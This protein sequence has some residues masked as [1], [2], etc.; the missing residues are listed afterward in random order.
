MPPQPQPPPPRP[1][2]K[3][4]SLALQGG[5]S[6]GA[7]T[8]GVLDAL[9]AAPRLLIEA[10]SGTSAGAVN[11]VGL[12]DGWARG[13]GAVTPRAGEP[14]TG[15]GTGRDA[16]PNAKAGATADDPRE[17][18]RE[19]ARRSL[20]GLW[21]DIGQW[22]VFGAVQARFAQALWGGPIAAQWAHA[23]LWAQAFGGFLSPYQTNPLGLNPLQDLLRRRIDFAALRRPGVPRV[24][25]S[26][27]QV[28]TGKAAIFSG[29]R[30]DEAAVMASACLPT[31]FQ[32][33]EIGGQ[34]YWDGGYSVNPALSPLIAQCGEHDLVV[35]QI[36]PLRRS[37][38]PDHAHEILDRI[39]ELNFNAS[40]LA[41]MRGIDRINRLLADGVLVGSGCRPVRL[42]R[43]DGGPALLAYS[44]ATKTDPDP[45]LIRELFAIGQEAGRRWLSR[46][47]EDLG[48]RS[49]VDVRRDYEDDT[50]IDWPEVCEW[51]PH[52]SPAGP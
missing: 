11:A 36:N 21:E 26:A 13:L 28:S 35:V 3:R 24:Y 34:A 43:I 30:L 49:T 42:H 23:N 4:L 48:Q 2:P 31:L 7:F 41:Q 40:L 52:D 50:R 29:T 44:A 46:H 14:G 9:L 51:L 39:N 37:D 1:A 17:A 38:R 47:F 5:G 27:T 15:P 20:A 6:H 18:P 10:L 16:T 32:A 33:V 45:G 22:G 19:A 25:V 8:W 12:A